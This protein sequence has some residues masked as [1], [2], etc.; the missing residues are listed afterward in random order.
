MI[1]GPAKPS[2]IE[3][4]VML[5]PLRYPYAALAWT[6]ILGPIGFR[7]ANYA[8]FSFPLQSPNH[9]NE[10][11]SVFL[12]FYLYYVVRYLRF[13]VLAAETSLASIVAE[14]EQA[15]Q[16]IFGRLTANGPILL[17]AIIIEVPAYLST[18][19]SWGG[20][21]FGGIY[22]LLTQII[23][24]TAF[25]C[26]IWEYALASWGLHRLGESPLKLKSFLED[27]FMGARAVGNLAL[28]L[29]VAYLVGTLL[30]FIQLTTFLPV[31]GNIGFEGFFLILLALGVIMFFLPLNSVHKKMQAEKAAQQKVL[32]QQFLTMRQN[33]QLQT[34]NGPATL[35]KL[36]T[37]INGLV[38]LKDLEITE[39]KLANTPTWPFDVNLLAKLIT[40]ILSVTAVLLSRIITNFLHI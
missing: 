22:N 24:I 8:A 28:S 38:Q 19:P 31:F 26:F 2:L 13:R 34:S 29:T 17:V 4:F 10:V 16:P 14:G 21:P 9:G 30:F 23:E 32:N 11:S 1:T 3:R 7:A 37:A 20:A 40:I 12:L 33:G 15:Y 39:K 27:R 6:I 18:S 36:E 5:I 35:E 25:S